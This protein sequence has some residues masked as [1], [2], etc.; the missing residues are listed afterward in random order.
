MSGTTVLGKFLSKSHFVGRG[1]VLFDVHSLVPLAHD[2]YGHDFL[3][4]L[5]SRLLKSAPTRNKGQAR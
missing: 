2:D 3:Q 1:P 5:I 4:P